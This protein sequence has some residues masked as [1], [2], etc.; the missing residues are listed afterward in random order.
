MPSKSDH[1]KWKRQES[2][3]WQLHGISTSG[4]AWRHRT[5]ALHEG[6]IATL[7]AGGGILYGV[8]APLFGLVSNQVVVMTSW[9]DCT[10]VEHKVTETLMAVEGMVHIN[11]HMPEDD[12]G[13]KESCHLPNRLPHQSLYAG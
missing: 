5:Q 13:M 10:G 9:L 4:N 1:G 8:W 3:L 11:H 2:N 6:G 7:G 12:P